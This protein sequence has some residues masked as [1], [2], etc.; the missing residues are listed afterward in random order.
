[1]PLDL[2]WRPKWTPTTIAPFTT[3]ASICCCRCHATTNMVCS[4]CQT[5][6]SAEMFSANLPRT[7]P[8]P[9]YRWKFHYAAEVIWHCHPDQQVGF[10]CVFVCLSIC[11]GIC[12][13]LYQLWYFSSNKQTSRQSDS[14]REQDATLLQFIGDT[15][16]SVSNW[17]FLVFYPCT[18]EKI[19]TKYF[20]ISSFNNQNL[21]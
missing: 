4:H 15:A 1:M 9:P 18:T 12:T 14:R 16:C 13:P 11:Y 21:N 10:V 7:S 8:I 17:D 20:A 19:L 2:W 3:L 6:L 5:I